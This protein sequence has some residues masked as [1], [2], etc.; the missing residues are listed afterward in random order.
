M[1]IEIIEGDGQA[2]VISYFSPTGLA[3]KLDVPHKAVMVCIEDGR[4]PVES[5]ENVVNKRPERRLLPEHALAVIDCLVETHQGI[6]TDLENR[7]IIEGK[8]IFDINPAL[9]PH[10]QTTAARRRDYSTRSITFT[11]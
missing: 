6:F 3:R 10:N 7:K 9:R 11:T 4:I 2:E 1:Q 5:G 8:I